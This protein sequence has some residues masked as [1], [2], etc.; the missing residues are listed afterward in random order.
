VTRRLREHGPALAF[1]GL[2]VWAMTFLGLYGFGWNDYENEVLPA[3]DALTA[4]HVWSFLTLA[5]A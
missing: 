4:G 5:P 2:G 1:A 3:Y